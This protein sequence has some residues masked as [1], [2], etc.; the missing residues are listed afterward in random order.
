[1]SRIKRM[2]IGITGVVAGIVTILM[3]WTMALPAGAT[4]PGVNCDQCKVL[5]SLQAKGENTV[6]FEKEGQ[7]VILTEPRVESKNDLLAYKQNAIH[8]LAS[9]SA[10]SRHAAAVTFTGPLSLQEVEKA[11]SEVEVQ[12]LRYVSEPSGGGKTSY[13]P[14]TADMEQSI[15]A[16]MK[17]QNGSQDFRLVAGYVAAEVYGIGADLRSLQENEFV[18]LVDVGAVELLDKYPGAIMMVDDVYYRYKKYQEQEGKHAA[19]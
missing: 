13:P 12:R 16:Y 18:F 8:R 7:V 17:E 14:T 19:E 15:A 3:L 11:L 1:M 9:L 4:D 2:S 6:A 10:S 5:Q